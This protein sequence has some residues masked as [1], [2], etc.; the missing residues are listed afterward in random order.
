VSRFFLFS[1][2]S[3]PVLGTTQPPIQL[4]QGALSPGVERPGREADHSPP[5]SAESR[6]CGSIHALPHT[7]SWRSAKLVKHRD[8]FIYIMGRFCDGVIQSKILI[9]VE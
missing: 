1:T 2:S 4:V 7:P 6:K 3:R 9:S 5:T 8:N